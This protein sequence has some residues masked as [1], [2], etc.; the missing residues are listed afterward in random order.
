MYIS[1][2]V[3]DGDMDAFFSHENQ[4]EPL[5]LS[6]MGELRQGTKSDLVRCFDKLASAAESDTPEVDAKIL[7]GSI[8]VNML[9]PKACSTFVDYAKQMFLPYVLRNLQNARYRDIVWDRYIDNSLRRS[10]R[11]RRGSRHHILV[12]TSTPI[13]KNW[14]SFLR[15]DQ[16]KTELYHYMSQRIS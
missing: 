2:Q 7:D 8:I 14:Q 13:S 12:K 9:L 6:D 3:R 10:A 1:C 15:V 16:N 5:S 11:Q 4:G